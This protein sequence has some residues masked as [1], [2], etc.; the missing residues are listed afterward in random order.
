M[1]ELT[2][3]TV[4]QLETL[5]DFYRSLAAN[6]LR[7]AIRID[8]Q[9]EVAPVHM[10]EDLK[11]EQRRFLSTAGPANDMVQRIKS[12]MEYRNVQ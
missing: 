9:L 3:L 10:I 8:N 6:M 12:E 1:V 11:N 7:N 2:K 5:N 4:E